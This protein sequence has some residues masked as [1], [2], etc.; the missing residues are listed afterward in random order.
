MRKLNQAMYQKQKTILPNR[1]TLFN[2]PEPDVCRLFILR[3]AFLL[4]DKPLVRLSASEGRRACA[5][6]QIFARSIQH[7]SFFPLI[8]RLVWF[9]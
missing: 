6:Q 8:D 9:F 3:W 7:A 5:Q 4:V 2:V 1:V